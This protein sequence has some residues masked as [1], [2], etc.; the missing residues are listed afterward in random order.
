MKT[1]VTT[2]AI[3]AL[4]A[5]MTCMPVS[6]AEKTKTSK[7]TEVKKENLFEKGKKAVVKA[8]HT[9]ADKS[10]EVYDKTKEGTV[11]TAEKVA[12]K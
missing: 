11:E 5:I 9:V 4:S 3:I 1:K 8:A 6:A 2:T 12:D 7:D 10:V